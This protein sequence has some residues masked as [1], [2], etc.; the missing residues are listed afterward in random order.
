MVVF[1]VAGLLAGLASCLLPET[2]GKKLPETV[3]DAEATDDSPT[4]WQC[5]RCVQCRSP[6]KLSDQDEQTQEGKKKEEEEEEVQKNGAVN[7]EE[8]C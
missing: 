5:L 1:T 2:G 4:L 6:P 3:E 7:S 8:T